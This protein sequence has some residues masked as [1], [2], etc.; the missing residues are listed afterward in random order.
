MPPKVAEIRVAGFWKR[1]F[2]FTFDG[3]LLGTFGFVLGLIWFEPLACLGLS[4]RLVGFVIGLFFF[5]FMN[6]AAS[7]G[8][9]MGKLL[10]NIKVTNNEGRPLG[11]GKSCLRY[12]VLSMPFFLNVLLS[13]PAFL[14]S[15]RGSF[16]C[17]I[18]YGVGLSIVYL[19][20]FNRKTGQ[21]LHDLVV[22]SFVISAGQGEGQ[23]KVTPWRGHYVV[24]CLL[25]LASGL[26]PVIGFRTSQKEPFKSLLSLERILEQDPD[27]R[28]AVPTLRQN[29]ADTSGA[30]KTRASSLSIRV[31]L[32]R[33]P[34]DYAF[35]ADKVVRAVFQNYPAAATNDTV[36]VTVA[37]GYDI[38]ISSRWKTHQFD[39]SP[40]EWTQ[41]LN[42]QGYKL[43]DPHHD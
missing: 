9:T 7:G 3:F 1:L 31:V 13:W 24:V 30:R 6:S 26:L 16:F 32:T 33:A 21:S 41:R 20:L 28:S 8:Q 2:A 10:L 15:L 27:I 22:G 39:L 37:Y 18:I 23:I 38:G 11:I 12:A 5:G 43:H 4:G 17:V 40:A 34:D 25:L 14:L 36:A 35:V 19:F 29:A 42:S